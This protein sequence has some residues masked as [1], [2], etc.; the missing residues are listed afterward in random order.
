MVGVVGNGEQILNMV[1]GCEY[2]GLVLHEF[3]HAIGYFHE[4]NRPDRDD[5]VEVLWDNVQPGVLKKYHDYMY[6]CAWLL[7]KMN[8]FLKI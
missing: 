1:P 2:V 3:G 8:I 5:V 7:L 6:V 4:H